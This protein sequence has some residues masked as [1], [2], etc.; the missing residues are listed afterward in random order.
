MCGHFQLR[1]RDELLL[2]RDRHVLDLPGDRKG[3][4]GSVC[5]EPSPWQPRQR[6]PLTCGSGRNWL[7]CSYWM[8]VIWP[9]CTWDKG[10]S[11]AVLGLATVPGP[12]QSCDPNGGG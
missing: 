9:S 5:S 4:E 12:R 3:A 8:W 6:Q 10:R 7:P 2:R 11:G 1:L